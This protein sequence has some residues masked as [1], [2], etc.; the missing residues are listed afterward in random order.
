[1]Q[2]II[3]D[4]EA[5]NTLARAIH[6]LSDRVEALER[7]VYPALSV[8]YPFAH[9]RPPGLVPSTAQ[10]VSAAVAAAD[11]SAPSSPGVSVYSAPPL[12]EHHEDIKS[13]EGTSVWKIVLIVGSFILA[14]AGAG[15]GAWWWKRNRG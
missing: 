5:A 13:T 11:R 7:V 15:F 2:S 12:V 10:V 4:T 1:M 3:I 6:R 9:R 8:P 14:G